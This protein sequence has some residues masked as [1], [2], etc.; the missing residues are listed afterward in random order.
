[1][2][3]DTNV[4]LNDVSILKEEVVI[5]YC[6][7]RELDDLKT[8]GG[9]VGYQSRRATRAIMDNIDNIKLIKDTKHNQYTDDIII[10]LA[11]KN[12]LTIL[13]RDLN[14]LLKAK[15]EN[16][17]CIEHHKD[18]KQISNLYNGTKEIICTPKEINSFYHKNKISKKCDYYNQV[19]TLTDGDK[20]AYGLSKGKHIEKLDLTHTPYDLNPRGIEQKVALSL[21]MDKDILLLTFTGTFGSSKTILSLASALEQVESGDYDKLLL[22]KPPISLDRQME[23]GFKPGTLEEKYIHVMSSITSNLDVLI[24]KNKRSTGKQHLMGLIEQGVVEIISLEDIMGSSYSNSIILLDEGQ[25]LDVDTMRAVVSRVGEN[26]KLIITGDMKQKASNNISTDK[27]GLFHLIESMKD[28]TTT[29]HMTLKGQYRSKLA[30]ELNKY[31]D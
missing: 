3:I 17:N 5:P 2:I 30:E 12:D 21:A 16:I 4:L 13:T 10:D 7:I 24:E 18:D 25:L 8:R 29:A 28:A 19:V 23:V 6:V 15:S 1:M 11:V 27:S 14:M 22:I 31:Y 20:N 26:S 9:E